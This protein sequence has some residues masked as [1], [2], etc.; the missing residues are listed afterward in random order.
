MGEKLP[1][2]FIGSG[3]RELGSFKSSFLWKP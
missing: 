1:A 2:V 3:G